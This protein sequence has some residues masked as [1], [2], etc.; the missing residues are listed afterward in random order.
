M[1]AVKVRGLK[2]KS[3]NQPRPHLNHS[4][5]IRERP[6]SNHSQSLMARNFAAILPIDPKFSALKDLNPFK[7]LPKA[8]EASS[9]LTVG[10]ALSN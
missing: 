7:T 5:H 3:A 2:K 9:I 6:G 8:Q 10:L 4:A 1:L